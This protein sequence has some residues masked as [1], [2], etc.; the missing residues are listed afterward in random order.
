MLKIHKF[1]L[2]FILLIII[3]FAYILVSAQKIDTKQDNLSTTKNKI[4]NQTNKQTTP[5]SREM[6]EDRYVKNISKL[7]DEYQSFLNS[8]NQKPKLKQLDSESAYIVFDLIE[9]DKIEKISEN[10]ENTL[11]PSKYKN[12]HLLLS[13][14]LLR[15]SSYIN[16][17]NQK[18]MLAGID[19]FEK[20]KEEY[21]VLDVG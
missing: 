16:T 21:D 7:S 8:L 9:K 4:N 13:R 3:L 2:S 17:S 15:L 12:F 18:D 5:I 10:L 1:F 11:V 20:A 14:S 6:Q 19:L